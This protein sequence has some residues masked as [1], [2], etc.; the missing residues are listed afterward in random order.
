MSWFVAAVIAVELGVIVAT[1]S[2]AYGS[3]EVA[4]L[5]FVVAT[6]LIGLLTTIKVRGNVVGR[7]LLLAAFSYATGGL[8]V[9]LVESSVIDPGGALYAV[10]TLAGNLAFGLG[11]GVLA[12]FVLLFFPTGKLRSRGW[13]VVVWA[14]G[15]GLTML[16]AGVALSP[17]TFDDLPVENPIALEDADGLVVLLEGGGIYLLMA[18][19]LASVVSLIVRFQRGTAVERQQLK[20][21]VLS[22]VVMA[23]AAGGVLLWEL[24]NGIGEVSDDVEN[25]VVTLALALIPVA[26]GVAILRYRL[27]DI[28]RIISRTVTYGLITAALVGIYVAIVFVLTNLIRLEGDL[29]VAGATL[30]VAALFSPLRRRLQGAID[31]RFNRSGAA[32]A[33]VVENFT[34]LLPTR[35]DLIDLTSEVRSVVSQTMQPAMMSVWLRGEAN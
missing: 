11:T 15:V 9:S 23:A 16:L 7:L 32:A 2:T 31:R 28:D 18:A 29:A 27:Y 25:V 8:G 33:R 13:R 10:A 12:T 20:W 30:G 3:A 35:V 5:V 26:I 17:E 24:F 22:V 6:T 34:R 1:K 21:V 19:I 14:A 4:T